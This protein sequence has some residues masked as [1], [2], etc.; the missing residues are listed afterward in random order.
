MAICVQPLEA[1]MMDAELREVSFC[2]LHYCWKNTKSFDF[3]QLFQFLRDHN[4]QVQQIALSNLIGQTAKESPH[5]N[6]FF[7]ELKGLGLQTFQET[8]VIHDLKLLCR[9]QLVQGALIFLHT[10]LTS[11]L[12]Q[13][14]TMHYVLSWTFQTQHFLFP[15]W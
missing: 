9:D 2:C 4:P 12:R 13:Q 15:S 10:I 8:D 11:R 1:P 6:I 5:Q 7:K 3:Y 14:H